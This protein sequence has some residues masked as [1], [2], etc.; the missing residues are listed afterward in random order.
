MNTQGADHQPVTAHELQRLFLPRFS[1][2]Q[3]SGNEAFKF[4]KNETTK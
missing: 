2:S 4:S 3:N 1:G